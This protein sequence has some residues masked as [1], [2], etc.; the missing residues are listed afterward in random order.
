M[1]P[2]TSRP[3]TERSLRS[4]LIRAHAASLF[5]LAP[6]VVILS[7]GSAPAAATAPQES[8]PT[9]TAVV[10]VVLAAAGAERGS[11]PQL[12]RLGLSHDASSAL[13]LRAPFPHCG[14][15]DSSCARLSRSNECGNDV[16]G[17]SG[18]CVRVRYQGVGTSTVVASRR[19]VPR[20]TGGELLPGSWR[21]RS[22]SARDVF[23][24]PCA[25]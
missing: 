17:R 12:G 15:C 13:N 16:S 3:H 1:L 10:T 25:Q 22:T 7:G 24:M 11:G 9:T 20:T 6:A 21:D 8:I 19:C 5:A 2:S 4:K 18:Q 14:I 23:A